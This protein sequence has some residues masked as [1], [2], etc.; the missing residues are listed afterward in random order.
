MTL[1]I[2]CYYTQ[3]EKLGAIKCKG[4]GSVQSGICSQG[5]HIWKYMEPC[6]PQ[7]TTLPQ[8]FR[9]SVCSDGTEKVFMSTVP[10][11]L[12]SRFFF[13]ETEEAPTMY[14]T[15][16]SFLGKVLVRRQ[17]FCYYVCACVRIAGC[18]KLVG[19]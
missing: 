6:S 8:Q 4:D 14:D 13:L 10:P 19:V 12:P 11:Y 7:R 1:I 2:S 16:P 17:C 18:Q 3:L 15:G 5:H 9:C